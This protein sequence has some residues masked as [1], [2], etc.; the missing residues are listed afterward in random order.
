MTLS[1]ML[2]VPMLVTYF[3]CP[4]EAED[5]SV[6]VDVILVYLA[7]YADCV[8]TAVGK[9]M[10]EGRPSSVYKMVLLEPLVKKPLNA[11]L[12]PVPSTETL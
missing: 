4:L 2:L 3:C 9:L 7:T 1:A 10:D 11:K 6:A 5:K 12:L 8:V